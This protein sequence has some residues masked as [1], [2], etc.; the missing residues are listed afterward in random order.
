MHG[1]RT[2]L[3]TNSAMEA[4]SFRPGALP[5]TTGMHT[6]TGSAGAGDAQEV[7]AHTS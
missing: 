3:R 4:K 7:R 1:S 5:S 2:E 6:D